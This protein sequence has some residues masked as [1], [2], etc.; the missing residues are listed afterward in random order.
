MSRL[1]LLLYVFGASLVG[2]LCLGAAFVLGMRRDD[3]L[4]RAFLFF[5]LPFSFLVLT[6]LVAV[7]GETV[8]AL[9]QPVV[10]AAQYVES[11]P[12]RYG[13]M[14]ALPLFAHR[15]YAVHAPNRERVLVQV[16]GAAFLLQHLT[17]FVLGGAWDLRGDVAE[18]VL[19]ALMVGYTVVVAV[20]RRTVSGVYPPLASRFLLVFL[21]L[22]PG[23]VHD[24][25]LVE[26]PGFRAYPLWYAVMGVVLVTTLMRRS[27]A[28]GSGIPTEWG[29]TDREEDVVELLARGRTNGEIAKDLS[30]SVNTVKTHLS[31]IYD[32]SGHRNRMALVAALAGTPPA[33]A[34]AIRS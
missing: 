25:F 16:V 1:P 28:L 20:R 14:L 13:L 32:K 9:P 18:D 12:G 11:F 26:G 22:V 3:P 34:D 2:A 17:E 29:L 10:S 33:G 31:S 24:V 6:A 15:V 23:V 19:F 30:I 5:Y 27:T 8:A 21:L 7:F 4:P